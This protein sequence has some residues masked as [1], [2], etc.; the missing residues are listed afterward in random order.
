MCFYARPIHTLVFRINLY[1]SSLPEH[2]QLVPVLVLRPELIVVRISRASLP[3]GAHRALP[4]SRLA[5]VAATVAVAVVSTSLVY[6]F[7]LER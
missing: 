1:R 5:F 2:Q 6:S 3:P 7:G 4:I